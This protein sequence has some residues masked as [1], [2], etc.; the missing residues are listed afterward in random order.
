MK[1]VIKRRRGLKRY[2]PKSAVEPSS[3]EYGDEGGMAMYQAEYADNTSL[4]STEIKSESK[5]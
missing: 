2:E 5:R 3:E 4:E 1:S